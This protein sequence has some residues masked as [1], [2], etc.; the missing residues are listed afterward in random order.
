VVRS[1][2]LAQAAGALSN[3]SS[4][5]WELDLYVVG[6][7]VMSLRAIANLE[8]ICQQNLA[9]NYRIEVIDLDVHP[10]LAIEHNI[11]A[12]PTLVRR[13]PGPSRRII[14]DLSDAATVLLGLEI[15]AV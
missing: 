14:G 7:T 11:T 4:G 15:I 13:S 2:A 5:K 8:H 3:A 10:E 12:I 9:G 1:N 6:A